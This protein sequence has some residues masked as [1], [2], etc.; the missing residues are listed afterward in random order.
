MTKQAESHVRRTR[1]RKDETGAE[2]FERIYG[3]LRDRICLLVYPPGTVLSEASLAREFGVSRTPI[4]RVLH[5]LEF[6]G[7]V[8]IM[9][10]VGTIVTDI[11]LKTFKETYDLRMRLAE[12][13]GEL[14]PAHITEDHLAQVDQL[15]VRT[16][17]LQ[18]KPGKFEDYAMITNDLQNILSS[19]TG[20][21]PLREISELFYFRVARI[22]FTFLPQLGWEDIISAQFTELTEIRAAMASNDVRGVGRF[23]SQHLHR[24]LIR[25]SRFLVEPGTPVFEV[26][27]TTP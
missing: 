17:K 22:W 19:L 11:D 15:I 1:A 7:L 18:A 23:R 24:M 20:S 14:S 25:I 6:M 26:E 8:Q 2:R 13:M 21:A 5:R 4:R 10:G 3:E 12:L 16:K 9:N 27:T